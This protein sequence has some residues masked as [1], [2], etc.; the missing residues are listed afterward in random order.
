MDHRNHDAEVEDATVS[1][2]SLS[3]Y[4]LLCTKIGPNHDFRQSSKE[5]GLGPECWQSKQERHMHVT[6]LNR[7]MFDEF[8]EAR[9]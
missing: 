2:G 9:M 3:K 6:V 1:N 4:H 7:E 5:G 8:L